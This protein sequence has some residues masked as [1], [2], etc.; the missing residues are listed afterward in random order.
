MD[1]NKIDI[2]NISNTDKKEA[3]EIDTYLSAKR[4]REKQLRIKKINIIKKRIIATSIASASI[5]LAAAGNFGLKQAKGD[6]YIQGKF[7]SVTVGYDAR[8]DSN[9]YVIT[10]D[11]VQVTLDDAVDDMVYLSHNNGLTDA[12]IHIGLEDYF[13]STVAS[14]YVPVK[15]SEVIAAK[16]K[17][18]H[19]YELEKNKGVSR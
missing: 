9:G 15:E 18:Y 8:L 2:P 12:E 19:E 13:N 10:K 14:Q 6:G 7:S 3:I 1:N 16:E 4:N 17:A 11:G 5:A